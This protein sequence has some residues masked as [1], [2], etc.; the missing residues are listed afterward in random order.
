MNAYNVVQ[1]NATNLIM[2]IIEE[3]VDGHNCSLVWDAAWEIMTLADPT[4]YVLGPFWYGTHALYYYED[5][6][7]NSTDNNTMAT[8]ELFDDVLIDLY[9]T[10]WEKAYNALNSSALMDQMEELGGLLA[11]NDTSVADLTPDTSTSNAVDSFFVNYLNSSL[12]SDPWNITNSSLTNV[13]GNS[14]NSSLA[15]DAGNGTN[16][17]GDW[18]SA[19]NALSAD[20]ASL[21]TAVPTET[22]SSM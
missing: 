22:G 14:T 7:R 8:I 3:M 13:P 2:P 17:T 15:I 12:A 11:T 16:L 5:L 4:L 10:Y 19:L 20:L 21:Q 1:N 18:T 9:M 6:V